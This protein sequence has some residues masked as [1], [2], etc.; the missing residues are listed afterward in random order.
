MGVAYGIPGDQLSELVVQGFSKVLGYIA[1]II[2]SAAITGKVMEETGA[3]Y[4]VSRTVLRWV[5][6]GRSPVATGLA[7]YLLALPVMCCDTA[8]I[9]LSPLAKALSTG[10]GYGLQL[11]TLALATGTFTSFK[12]VFPAAP[13]FPTTMFGADVSKVILLGFAASVSVFITGLMLSSA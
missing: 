8:F 9:M 13:L 7:G 5:G 12:L 2:V 10:S 11:F 3:T 4:V 6:R 1:I